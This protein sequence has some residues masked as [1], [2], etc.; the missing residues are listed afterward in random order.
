MESGSKLA[1]ERVLKVVK[2]IGG[3]ARVKHE[4]AFREWEVIYYV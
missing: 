2:T 3:K 1:K 4:L